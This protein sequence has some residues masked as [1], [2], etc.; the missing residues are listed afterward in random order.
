MG[1]NVLFLSYF[2][3]PGG[4]A[5][6]QRP[7]K[8]AKYLPEF[9]I[10]PVILAGPIKYESYWAP[11]DVSL[12][13][14]LP[15]NIHIKR[16]KQMPSNKE[17]IFEKVKTIF[18]GEPT[19]ERW[20]EKEALKEADKIV[21]ACKID[22][23]FATLSPYNSA[24]IARKIGKKKRIPWIID[25]RDPWALDEN[26]VYPSILNRL[27]D[28]AKMKKEIFAASIVIMNTP[29][30][31]ENLIKKFPKITN[32]KVEI[33]TNGYDESD[34]I[35]QPEKRD[36]RHF[37][38]VHT[39]FLHTKI[40]L[41]ANHKRKYYRIFG[42]SKSDVNF[43]T[44][45]HF[46]LMIA[47]EK[48][49][50]RIPEFADDFELILA[51]KNSDC[52]KKVIENSPLYK[53]VIFTGYLPH[54]ESIN[55]LRTTDMLFLPMQELSKGISATIVPGKLYEY[56]ASGRPILGAVPEG[57]AR[58]YLL[59]NGGNYVVFPSDVEE[60]ERAIELE[61]AQW[62]KTGPKKCIRNE[63]FIKIFERRVLTEKLA[64]LFNKCL[65]KNDSEKAK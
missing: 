43:L 44:R 22:I 15:S 9:G 36:D 45:S 56:L 63:E 35:E 41:D 1:I 60:M 7:L 42:K 61:Y 38:I 40:G 20:W 39:G 26:R 59:K 65:I 30:A 6:S 24:K 31:K 5:G 54:N 21:Y 46:Y 10:S 14:E 28:T 29:Q 47:V 32:K 2:F 16:I 18:S 62:K 49:A 50:K 19:H 8:F 27:F 58:K 17:N 12:L 55:L 23:I 48:V 34:F 13:N 11:E 3:P 51:G 33:I 57:D 37:R 25:L 52:D 53:N 64:I 4:G